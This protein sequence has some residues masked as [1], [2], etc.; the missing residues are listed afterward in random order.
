MAELKHLV[1]RKPERGTL[2][3]MLRSPEAEF[4]A[5]YGRRRVGKT[6]LIRTYLEPRAGVF[7]NVTG[8][9]DAS[10]AQQL[11][12]YQEEYERVFFDGARLPPVRSWREGLG[13]LADAVE[14]QA[15]RIG[16][17]PIVLFFDELPWLSTPRSGL[18]QALDYCWNQRLS[19]IPAVKLVVCGSAA[20]WI[21]NK[22]IHAKGGLYNRITRRM[23]LE[24][25]KLKEAR[26]LLSAHGYRPNLPQL[27]EIYL[28]M[29]GVP[30]YLRQT[31]K[32]RS[33]AENI[34]L[35]CFGPS[36]VL[37]DEFAHLMATLFSR[38]EIHESIVRALA[39][40]R[41]G[42]T[43]KQILAASSAVSGGSLARAL[44]ELEEAGFVARV[45]PYSARTKNTV[46][47]LID[48]YCGFYLT[49]IASAPRSVL[50]DDRA[51]LSYWLSRARST[52]YRTWAGYAFEGL[53]LK[54]AQ[55]LKEGL[56]ISAVAA[57]VA[58][59]R[60]VPKTRSRKKQ[61]AQVDLLFD[62]ED[63]VINL[64]EMKYSAE[65]FRLTRATA[66]ELMRKVEIFQE[67]TRTRKQ[68]LVTLVTPFGVQDSVWARELV[69]RVVTA[70]D[71][72]K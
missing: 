10:R 48:E 52:S 16:E 6:H 45:P 12:N 38:S 40:R 32:G 46:F 8:Q 58:S 4:L 17:D 55:E 72:V 66:Q 33:A 57:E 11:L 9:K 2:D 19:R 47:R 44:R 60:H 51:A 50:N 64:C 56:G 67:V 65:P 3:D 49:W 39:K 24:P 61:G 25:F 1:G 35:T 22:L 63:G 36:G 71:L 42:L 29:G 28:A 43:R 31:Q 34:A 68:I 53:C 5:L 20:S 27:L 59:W 41:Q 69:D 15:P 30:H 54:H 23:R 70:E 14:R 21:L 13:L 26:E 18:I 7:F 62:R 37:S